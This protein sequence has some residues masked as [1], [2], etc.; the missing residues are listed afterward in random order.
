MAQD[1]KGQARAC[2]N[3]GIVYYNQGNFEQAVIYFEKLFEVA[4]TLENQKILDIARINLG[5][6]RGAARMNDYIPIVKDNLMA[7]LQW[8]SNRMPFSNRV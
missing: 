2:G 3:L 6:A 4:R 8:K 7:L 5:V 1:S